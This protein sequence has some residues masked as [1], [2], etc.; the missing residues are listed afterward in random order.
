MTQAQPVAPLTIIAIFAGIIEASALATLPFLSE[1]SQKLYT[2]FLVGFP[3]F[4]TALF[5]L[6]LNFNYKSFYSPSPGRT[7]ADNMPIPNN[8]TTPAMTNGPHEATKGEPVTFMFSGPDA[9]RMMEQQLLSALAHPP[10]PAR[11]WRFCNLDRRQ[12]AQ[13][14]IS[15]LEGNVVND[16]R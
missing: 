2:W 9:N 3:F 1:S 15:A 14:S 16:E 12:C 13:L 4:L 7:T 5:F 11:T 8:V 6:T 10:V